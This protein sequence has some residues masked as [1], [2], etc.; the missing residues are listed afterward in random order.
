MYEAH[1][2]GSVL[3]FGCKG[4][5]NPADVLTKYLDWH[6]FR[7]AMLYIMNDPWFLAAAQP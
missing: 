5:V 3:F 4:K 6:S 7:A 1:D 2:D